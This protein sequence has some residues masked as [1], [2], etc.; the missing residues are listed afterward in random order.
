MIK[1][2]GLNLTKKVK[3]QYAENYKTLIKETEDNTKKWKALP[4][5]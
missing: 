5:S 2:L 4:C 1:Y 3:D